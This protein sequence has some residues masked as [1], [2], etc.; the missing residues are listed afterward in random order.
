MKQEIDE[1]ILI[2]SQWNLNCHLRAALSLHPFILI[3]SQWNLN[4]I[5]K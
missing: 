5:R 2:E 1:L 3:E 4:Y